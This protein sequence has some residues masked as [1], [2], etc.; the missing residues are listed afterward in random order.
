M[1]YV[2]SVVVYNRLLLFQ[3]DI[4]DELR[5][6]AIVVPSSTKKEDCTIPEVSS[7]APRGC[8]ER[9]VCST[10]CLREL[11]ENVCR[12]TRCTCSPTVSLRI[13]GCTVVFTW[14]C[15]HQHRGRLSRNQDNDTFYSPL[16]ISNIVVDWTQT[17]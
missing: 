17:T 3:S 4:S 15:S 10:D 16:V 11:T 12:E 13:V 5:P 6:R 2:V 7:A 9:V 14:V 8:T 1:H